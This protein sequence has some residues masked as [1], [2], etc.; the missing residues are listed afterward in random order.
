MQLFGVSYIGLMTTLQ[1][2]AE[3]EYK[4]LKGLQ[5][6]CYVRVK[7]ERVRAIDIDQ[8]NQ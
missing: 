3:D 8:Q 5:E 6:R 4:Y 2:F 1:P 7:G